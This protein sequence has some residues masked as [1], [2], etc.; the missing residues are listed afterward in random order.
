MTL[1]KSPFQ[2]DGGPKLGFSG[3]VAPDRPLLADSFCSLWTLNQRVE[4]CGVAAVAERSRT[5]DDCAFASCREGWR[6]CQNTDVH[7]A[8]PWI[9][10]SLPSEG[11]CGVNTIF[12]LF[13][14]HD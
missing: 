8:D 3:W 9:I 14:S 7:E 4:T 1:Q 10:Y 6:R 2:V 13:K 11:F 5:R 12:P